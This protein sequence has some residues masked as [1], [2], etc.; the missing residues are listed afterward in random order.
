MRDSVD[1]ALELLAAEADGVTVI[2]HCFS[3]PPE[4]VAGRRR[5]RLVL[6]VRRQPH[7]PEGR[8]AARGREAGP[9][10]APP[11]RDRRALPRASTGPRQAE[12]SRQRR[13][14]RRAGGR[15]PRRSLRRARARG[16]GQRRPGLRM[17]SAPRPGARQRRLGQNFLR[18]PNL[19]DAIVRDSGVGA[20][21]VVLEVGGGG[22]ALTERLAPAVSHLH[23]VE[24]DERL[25][26]ELDELAAGLGNVELHW[27]DAMR[28]GPR[29]PRAG[30]CRGRIEPALL[31]GDAA[32]PAHHRAPALGDDVDG[33]GPARDRRAARRKPRREDLRRAERARP[34]RLQ[35]R[36]GASRRSRRVQPPPP[37]RLRDRAAGEARTGGE[38]GAAAAGARG[39]RPPPQGAGGL[40]RARR[41]RASTATS[42]RAALASAGLPEDARAEALAPEDFER[43]AA[44]LGSAR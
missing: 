23:V 12:R 36:G 13:R 32:P 25:R 37:G 28:D 15:G 16:R 22:G 24:L 29:R 6:L 27:G 26:P 43:L 10:R 40:A 8:G 30:P 5:A 19:L 21:D 44:N 39:V 33:D 14:H 11:G 17:V 4:R 18:D 34:A 7:L 35:G 2:L 20:S 3:A 42:V 9:R 41:A 1:E 31:G 38:R